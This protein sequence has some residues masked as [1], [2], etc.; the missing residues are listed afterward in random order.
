MH[1]ESKF[2]KLGDLD[3]NKLHKRLVTGLKQKV[4]LV[5]S[6]I[7]FLFLKTLSYQKL[8]SPNQRKRVDLNKQIDIQ[9]NSHNG[10]QPLL[11]PNYSAVSLQQFLLLGP[12]S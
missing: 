8:H 7:I 6:Q 10:R 12:G 2:Y 5:F 4:S 11:D 9:T 3:L 1:F